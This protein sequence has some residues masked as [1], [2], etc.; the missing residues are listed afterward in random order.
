MAAASASAKIPPALR[1]PGAAPARGIAPKMLWLKLLRRSAG[2]AALATGSAAVTG[3]GL[4]YLFHIQGRMVR[5]AMDK[6]LRATALAAD[7]T[8]RKKFGRELKLAGG[9]FPRR[10]LRCN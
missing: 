2:W 7:R 8:Y 10:R 1:H 4:V 9:R 3:G 6:S 5:R